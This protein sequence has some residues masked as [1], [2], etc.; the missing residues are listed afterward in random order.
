LYRAGDERLRPDLITFNSVLG[1]WATLHKSSIEGNAR[2]KTGPNEALRR[3]ESLFDEMHRMTYVS[4][5]IISYNIMLDM[6]A[7]IPDLNKA[8]SLFMTILERARNRPDLFRGPDIIS[9]NSLLVAMVHDR[10]STSLN[11]ALDLVLT[12][13]GNNNTD[14]TS[15]LLSSTKPDILS[16]NIVLGGLASRRADEAEDF[17]RLMEKRYLEGK[18]MVRPNRVSYNVCIDAHA[19]LGLMQKA[20]SLLHEMIAVSKERKDPDLMPDAFT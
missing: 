14:G 13:D 15:H 5:C 7:R 9:Y 19:Q 3:A 16:F 8:E 4:P 10:N 1:A 11:R 20:E 2:I 6:Y 18:S 17:L 12:M